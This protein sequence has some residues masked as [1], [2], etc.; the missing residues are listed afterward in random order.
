MDM[1]K[2]FLRAMLIFLLEAAL[3]VGSS[4]AAE[5]GHPAN[6][7]VTVAPLP[8]FLEVV[9]TDPFDGQPLRYGR[10]AKGYVVYSVGQDR[11]DDG[12]KEKPRKGPAKNCDETFTV[13]R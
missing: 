12:G 4:A 2:H 5:N 6:P 7:E 1:K 13:E 3:D 11:Q 10:P 9:L 8:G